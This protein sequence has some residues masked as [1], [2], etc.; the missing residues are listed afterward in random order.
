VCFDYIYRKWL[1]N[2]HRIERT[3][4]LPASF[5][6]KQGKTAGLCVTTI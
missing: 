5:V 4:Y 1:V 2:V 3:G 6:E